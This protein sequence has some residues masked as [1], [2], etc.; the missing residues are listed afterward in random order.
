MSKKLRKISSERARTRTNGK[1][2]GM[3][4]TFAIR[5]EKEHTVY[6]DRALF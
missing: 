1:V 6:A 3:C 4:V 5:D 2:K